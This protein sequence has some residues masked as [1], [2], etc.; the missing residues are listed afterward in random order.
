[1]ILAALP[2]SELER[3]L[4]DG[5]LHVR[6]ERNRDSVDLAALRDEL[7]ESRRLG[8]AYDVTAGHGIGAVSAALIKYAVPPATG[9]AR[10][11]GCLV[12]VGAFGIESVASF[13]EKVAATAREMR[14]NVGSLQ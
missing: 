2:P 13:G 10:V 4:A 7:D 9:S 12:V 1:A 3:V 6:G 14:A 11:A 8:Y 5:S